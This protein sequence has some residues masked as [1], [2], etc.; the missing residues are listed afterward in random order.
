L[1]YSEN[2]EQSIVVGQKAMEMMKKNGSPATP[3]NYEVWFNF[4]SGKNQAVVEKVETAIKKEGALSDWQS[5]KI[6]DELLSKDGL[7]DEVERL[8]A[9]VSGE[10]AGIMDMLQQA[11]GKTTEYESSL[12]TASVELN[13]LED[14]DHVKMVVQNLIT[15]THEMRESNRELEQRLND[16]REQIGDLNRN[17]DSVRAEALTDQLTGIANRKQF[18][19]RI[20]ALVDEAMAEEQELCLLLGDIDHFKSFNDSYGHQTGDQVLRFVAHAMKSNLK[21]RDMPARYGGE[22]FAILLPGTSLK[23]AVIV[24]NQVRDAIR[25]KDLVKRS[26]GEKLGKVTI[27][28]G[29]ARYRP[30]EPINEFIHRADMCLYAAKKAGRDKVICEADAEADIESAVA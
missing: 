17:L 9:E 20:N 3:P 21:G 29:A 7:N 8:S 27:S 10:L 25:S 5:G 18:D 11:A 26:T 13:K 15:M 12:G 14:G 19:E 30:G 22:E 4:V 16:S 1:R 2:F 28:F 6:Y 24:G 23:G